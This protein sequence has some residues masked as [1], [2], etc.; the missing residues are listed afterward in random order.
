MQKMQKPS[1]LALREPAVASRK[2]KRTDSAEVEQRMASLG[3]ARGTGV[4]VARC[5][6]R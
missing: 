4:E 2:Q 3:V 1:A 6:P 5:N